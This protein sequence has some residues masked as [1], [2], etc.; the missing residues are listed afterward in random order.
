MANITLRST[1][2]SPV[3][4]TEIDTNFSTLDI[5]NR[6]ILTKSVSANTTLTSDEA[7][8]FFLNISGTGNVTIS[9]PNSFPKQWQ[10][11]NGTGAGAVI[12][13]KTASGAVTV[14][15]HNGIW[16]T[17]R[18][19]GTEVSS[20]FGADVL[21]CD[22]QTAGTNNRT[23]A[24]TQY[25]TTAVTNGTAGK[26]NR[27]GD[28]FTGNVGITGNLSATG[29]VSM[30]SAFTFRNRIINGCCR[31]AERGV[32]ALSASPTFGTVD[33]FLAASG[34]SGLAGSITRADV[35]WTASRKALHLANVTVTSGQ[36]YI[37]Y[38]IESNNIQDFNGKTVT[39]SCKIFHDFG[40]ATPFNVILYKPN[41]L[42]NHGSVTTIGQFVTAQ[43]VASGTVVTL[44]GS[45]T[46]GSTDAVNGLAF[47]V[48]PSNAITLTSK[49]IYYGDFHLELGLVVTPFELKPL[50]IEAI[51][52]QR[53]FEKSYDPGV[54]PGSGSG[55]HSG[56]LEQIAINSVDFY[57]GYVITK[58]STQK[59]KVPA[60]TFY[61][62]DGISHG[63]YWNYSIGAVDNAV[64][65]RF[66]TVNGFAVYGGSGTLQTNHIYATHWT[67]DAEI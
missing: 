30:S 56:M 53:Y 25:T 3:T 61:N 15:C 51:M 47:Q 48:I 55:I 35:N 10:V 66:T 60:M 27:S 37:L 13:I 40:T 43:S 7:D 2:G 17:I 12:Y 50:P 34:G 26:V 19:N 24:T 16:T 63:Y 41:S 67:A 64:F 9:V 6:G 20:G 18:S 62:P 57:S 39:F 44:T 29:T 28:T 65:N 46:L 32:G 8:N 21:Y 45:L 52:C 54:A 59:A 5:R 42:D 33:R 23:V 22:T 31:I 38:R 11:Y 4:Q 49:Q 14:P 1:K 36:P 58:F